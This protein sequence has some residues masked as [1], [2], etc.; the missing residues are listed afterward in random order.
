MLFRF[1]I[2]VRILL[3]AC[4][5]VSA[6]S[7][8]AEITL[9]GLIGDNM[10]LQREQPVQIT[11]TTA[12]GKTVTLSIASQKHL[13][14]ADSSGRWRIV[15]PPLTATRKGTDLE[16]RIESTSGDLLVIKNV[17]VGDVWICTGASNMVCPVMKTRE[18]HEV[19]EAADFPSIRFFSVWGGPS[20]E[21]KT[22]CG[23]V[24]LQCNPGT[25]EAFSAIGY[26][27]GR[28]LHHELDVPIG[29]IRNGWG[30]TRAEA[31]AGRKSLEAEPGLRAM[32][33]DWDRRPEDLRLS[34]HCPA[35]LF[36][37][38]MEPLT[39]MPI[40]GIIWSQGKAN[41]THFRQPSAVM[42]AMVRGW[43]E[44]WR[45]AKLPVALVDPKDLGSKKNVCE[46]NHEEIGR[47]L[48]DW[49]L[50]EVY[51]KTKL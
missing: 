23:G 3:L 43:R 42:T 1:N 49:A 4:V 31:W 51:G 50:S 37:G 30:G 33:V 11:G 35:A 24:W 19:I 9:H 21:P 22:D 36:N 16:M 17:L 29:L 41:D 48:A 39:Q 26:F 2:I 44:A 27:F 32:L 10:V 15:L 46:L 38:K 14:V 6:S 5:S 47:R 40:R 8:S 12:P 13:A 28:K 25:A 18:A 45:D 7:L 34:Q 20:E